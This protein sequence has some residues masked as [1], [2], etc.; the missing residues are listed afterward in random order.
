VVTEA[1]GGLTPAGAYRGYRDSRYFPLLDGLR[2]LSIVAVVW[3]H[4][5]GT[6]EG[7]LSRCREGVSLFFAISGFLITTLLLR[8]RSQT[9]SISLERF[10][11]RRALRIF[12]LYYAV[13]GLYAVSVWAV[14]RRSTAGALFWHNLPYFLTYTSNWFVRLDSDQVI[15]YF[16][17]SLA[18]EEQFYLFWPLVVK[19]ASRPGLAEGVMIGL[20]LLH[21]ASV[22]A[23]AMAVLPS[24]AVLAEV[25]GSVRLPICFGALAACLVHSP[26]GFSWAFPVA[27]QAWSGAV[28]LGAMLAGLAFDATP[29]WVVHLAMT[30]LVVSCALRPEQPLRPLLDNPVAR[31]VGK[32]SYGMYLLHVLCINVVRRLLDVQ[33]G[34]RV[35]L[36]GLA[37]SVAAATLSYRLFESPLLRLKDRIAGRP[38]APA[39]GARVTVPG[40]PPSAP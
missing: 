23:V 33:Q 40:G 24:H 35:F 5:A 1:H 34:P 28:A 39:G 9:G 31:H 3:H 19:K 36:G 20:A 37:L 4:A 21:C 38:D 22:G 27:G 26:K 16:A 11:V 15:F 13:L 14:E 7:L 17:W 30:W 29:A 10:Y 25:L 32:V 18:T 6:A 2:C 12:P 8:E